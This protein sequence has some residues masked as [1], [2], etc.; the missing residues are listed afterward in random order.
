M[1]CNVRPDMPMR[2]Q[3]LNTYYI[4]YLLKCSIENGLQVSPLPAVN[5]LQGVQH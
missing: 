2:L 3:I 4:F 5:S 1:Y